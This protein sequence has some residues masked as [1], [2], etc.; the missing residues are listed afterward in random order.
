MPEAQPMSARYSISE[1]D[2]Q[3]A[4]LLAGRLTRRGW[5]IML[6]VV[7]LIVLGCVLMIVT[8]SGNGSNSRAATMGMTTGLVMWCAMALS[9]WPRRVK[10]FLWGVAAF[11]L[12][13]AFTIMMDV[14]WSRLIWSLIGSLIGALVVC[15]IQYSQ[16]R[17]VRR[18]YEA[19]CR[20][21]TVTLQDGG[22]YLAPPDGPGL[23]AWEQIRKWRCDADYVLIYT[24]SD[25]RFIIP[26][27]IAEQ[28]FDVE[29]LKTALTQ[30]V[31][32]PEWKA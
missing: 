27:W 24:E 23:L 21:W 1:S 5:V 15:G 29:R 31:G 7:F 32:P 19:L 25:A 26:T 16:V 9:M 8:D 12:W 4:A 17:S 2:C 30:H 18:K 6:L 28:G 10:L 20:E 14:D 22:L 11:V 3:R 13:V